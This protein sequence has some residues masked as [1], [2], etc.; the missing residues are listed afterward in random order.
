M[1]PLQFLSN[2]FSLMAPKNATE[3]ANVS[4]TIIAIIVQDVN[5]HTDHACKY[6]HWPCYKHGQCAYLHPGQY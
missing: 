1:L 3:T 2:L 6:A 5:M 4:Y